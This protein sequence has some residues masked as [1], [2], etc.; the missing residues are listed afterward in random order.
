MGFA[1]IR[2]V[3]GLAD[4]LKTGLEDMEAARH[5]C[6]INDI[7]VTASMAKTLIRPAA[8]A[9]FETLLEIDQA[10]FAGGVAYDASELA[11]FMNRNGAETLVLE[12]DDEIAAFLILEVCSNRRSG[13]I[14]TLDVRESFRRRGYGSQLLSRAEDI[15]LNCGLEECDL[16]VDVTNRGAI[17]FYR[18]NGFRTAGTLRRY[19]ANGND[20]YVMVKELS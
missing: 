4:T 1:E 16:Q 2:R 9:D 3:Q 17:S 15:F 19:Y 8:P 14:V 11:Y 7:D 13:T 12:E 6:Y 10:S 18:K 5:G 20:A